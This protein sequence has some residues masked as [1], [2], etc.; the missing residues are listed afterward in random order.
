MTREELVKKLQELYTK[1][2]QVVAQLNAI[3]G[4]IEF[5]QQLIGELDKSKE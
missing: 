5:A 1:K 2:E 4:A 3:I